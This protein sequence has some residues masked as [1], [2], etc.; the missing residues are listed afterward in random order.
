MKKKVLF[1]KFIVKGKLPKDVK[2]V[3][4][5]ARTIEG[6][7]VIQVEDVSAN[8]ETLTDNIN[9]FETSAKTNFGIEEAFLTM[10]RMVKE[11]VTNGELTC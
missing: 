10:A 8:M 5:D 1:E 3:E 2:T 9:Y 7:P 6:Q 4:A 11:K